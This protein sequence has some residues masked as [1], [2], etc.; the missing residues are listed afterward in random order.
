MS[1]DDDDDDDGE[2]E[3]M[4]AFERSGMLDKID[5]VGLCCMFPISRV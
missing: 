4:E 2:A 3:D 1:Y 5:R